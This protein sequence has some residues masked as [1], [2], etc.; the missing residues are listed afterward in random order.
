MNSEFKQVIKQGFSGT[1][2]SEAEIL[3]ICL[4]F[5]KDPEKLEQVFASG[6]EFNISETQ[7]NFLAQYL[8][9]LKSQI[10]WIDDRD[11]SE[12][13]KLNSEAGNMQIFIQNFREEVQTIIEEDYE[14]EEIA[15]AL[16]DRKI[17]EEAEKSMSE[18]KKIKARIKEVAEK[19]QRALNYIEHIRKLENQ[20]GSLNEIEAS[21]A[22]RAQKV[23]IL[24]EHANHETTDQEAALVRDVMH[25]YSEGKLKDFENHVKADI[26]HLPDDDGLEYAVFCPTLLSSS[27]GSYSRS[28]RRQLSLAAYILVLHDAE[29]GSE[30]CFEIINPENDVS[31]VDLGNEDARKQIA[32]V[33]EEFISADESS[34]FE[35]ISGKYKAYYVRPWEFDDELDYGEIVLNIVTPENI[36]ESLLTE[37]VLKTLEP[38]IGDYNVPSVIEHELTHHMIL[39]GVTENDSIGDVDWDTREISS[40]EEGAAFAVSKIYGNDAEIDSDEYRRLFGTDPG[41]IDAVRNAMYNYAEAEAGG[42]KS[43]KRNAIITKAVEIIGELEGDNADALSDFIDDHTG[44]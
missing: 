16:E 29:T 42:R 6:A 9:E 22:N 25:L 37:R 18:L 23:E 28:N 10:E 39:R 5:G 2:R 27:G 12:L 11:E 41:D 8:E 26:T 44:S 35:F 38:K 3:D 36:D 19:E 24:L 14:L 1:G 20:L 33:Y 30:R 4:D 7:G 43:N 21:L 32:E 17:A 34:D 40:I 31:P 15:D 13:V